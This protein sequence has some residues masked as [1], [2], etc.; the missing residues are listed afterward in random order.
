LMAGGYKPQQGDVEVIDARETRCGVV[1]EYAREPHRMYETFMTRVQ[2]REATEF[3]LLVWDTVKLLEEHASTLVHFES[4]L[5]NS[6]LSSWEDCASKLQMANQHLRS[7]FLQLESWY[8]GLK[9][10][11]VTWEEEE[12]LMMQWLKSTGAFELMPGFSLTL[13]T[14]I[15]RIQQLASNSL[16]STKLNSLCRQLLEK[17]QRFGKSFRCIVFVQQRI[18]AHIVA[19]AINTTE[20]LTEVGLVA[21]YVTGQGK[22]TPSISMSASQAKDSLVRFRKG[23]VDVLVATAT[24]EEVSHARVKAK[25][26]LRSR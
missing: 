1:P 25:C 21:S 17:K 8:V 3:T 20:R 23:D 22:I 24:A 26:E 2:Q 15:D 16:N 7:F 14:E 12:P 9:L 18:C 11:V 5:K 4:P 6:K 13:R 19:H 10:L